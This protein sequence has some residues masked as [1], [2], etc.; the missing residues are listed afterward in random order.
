MISVWWVLV[1]FILGGFFGILI[2]AIMY[3]SG[4]CD[5]DD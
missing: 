2:S 3:A 4:G 5:K 1:A